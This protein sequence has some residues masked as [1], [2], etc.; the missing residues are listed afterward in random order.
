MIQEFI[1]SNFKY[2]AEEHL[3]TYPDG[4]DHLMISGCKT[5]TLNEDLV[6]NWMTRYNLFQGKKRES[7]HLIASEFIAYNSGVDNIESQSELDIREHFS[8]LHYKLYEI[9]IKNQIPQKKWLS[10]TSK[11][12]WCMFPSQIVIYDSFVVR[13]ITIL[14]CMHRE[15][16]EFNRVT[17]GP[18]K[19][20]NS[21]DLDL[22]TEHYMNYQN[23]VK[24]IYVANED[25]ISDMKQAYGLD[26]EYNIRLID[27]FLWLMGD[28]GSSF[29][30]GSISCEP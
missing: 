3:N 21:R 16:A 25:V 7:R 27:K 26:Y 20:E 30:L 9:S 4:I 13:A 15:L 19:L 6:V 8:D 11:L 17:N 5:N 29:Y 10:A 2:I 1:K 22:L 18:R 12:L 28:S 23:L 14:Q 24:K